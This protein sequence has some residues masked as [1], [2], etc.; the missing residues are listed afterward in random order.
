MGK[1]TAIRTALSYT[2]GDIIIIQ[3]A[4]LEYDPEDYNDLIKLIPEDKANA[5]YGST[6]AHKVF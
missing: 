6:L 1:V 5:V 4:D 3:D 2:T